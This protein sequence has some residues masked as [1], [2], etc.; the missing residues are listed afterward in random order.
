MA[1]LRQLAAHHCICQCAHKSTSLSLPTLVLLSCA[2]GRFESVAAR[3][4]QEGDRLAVILDQSA[5]GSAQP[6]TQLQAGL[7]A[8]VVTK[9]ETVAAKGFYTPA[10]E[11]PYMIADGVVTPL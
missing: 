7:V 3:A 1:L 4:V 11:S 9:I 6:G 5:T 10:L 8:V 2:V